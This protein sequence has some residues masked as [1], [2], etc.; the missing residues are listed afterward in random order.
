MTARTAPRRVRPPL[1]LKV[2]PFDDRD[3]AN[4]FD[5]DDRLVAENER[6]RS[7]ITEVEAWYSLLAADQ[8]ALRKVHA[9]TTREATALQTECHRL[10]AAN[11][12]LQA[13]ADHPG[14]PSGAALT[15]TLGNEPAV[16]HQEVRFMK[17]VSFLKGV[18]KS[19]WTI[20]AV[21]LA[22]LLAREPAVRDFAVSA[23][24]AVNP[25]RLVGSNRDGDRDQADGYLAYAR[26]VNA[27][28]AYDQ[29]RAAYNRDAESLKGDALLEA[30]DSLRAARQRDAQARAAFLPALRASCER[31]QVPFPAEAAALLAGLHEKEL[32]RD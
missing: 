24:K 9:R 18:F 22:A 3:D 6:L 14:G 21:A 23:A 17:F 2:H 15:L 10:A 29:A 28:A 25:A 11:E 5:T 13:L 26:M 8:E 20:P 30:Q 19:R 7:K 12:R 1:D 4:P 32:A 31:A 16:R 27:R